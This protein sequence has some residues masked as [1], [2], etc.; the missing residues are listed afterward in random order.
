MRGRLRRVGRRF[1]IELDLNL[2]CPPY[3]DIVRAYDTTVGPPLKSF[4]DA[5]EEDEE[6]LED[7]VNWLA[8]TAFFEGM[9]FAWVEIIAQHVEAGLT[10]VEKSSVSVTDLPAP[11]DEEQVD[12]D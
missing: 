9:R 7:G 6:R 12:V 11:W 2:E 3:V 8:L 10:T 5:I 4:V 1:H